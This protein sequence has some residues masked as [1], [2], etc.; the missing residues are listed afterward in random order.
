MEEGGKPG[1]GGVAEELQHSSDSKHSTRAS[2][3]QETTGI[4]VP[5]SPLRQ[6]PHCL[7]PTAGAGPGESCCMH[8]S[9]EM[10]ALG[11]ILRQ[12]CCGSELPRSPGCAPL[13][14]ALC[15]LP[16]MV[17]WVPRSFLPQQ[18]PV[19]AAPLGQ[20]GFYRGESSHSQHLRKLGAS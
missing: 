3:V 19:T 20:R 10:L 12:S 7:F 16:E 8:T 2:L 11:Q 6:C 13:L 15:K 17:S 14:P 1:F 9:W 18:T 5:L 4:K